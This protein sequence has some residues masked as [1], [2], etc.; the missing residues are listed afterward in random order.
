MKIIHLDMDAFYAS[1]EQRDDP[2]LRGRPVVVGGS[3]R[4]RGVVATASYE[5]RVYGVRSAMSCAEA[6]RR[7]PEAIF[8]PPDMAR[9]QEASRRVFGIFR[10]VTPIVEPLSIDEAYLDVT[11]NGLNEPLAGKVARYLK[12]RIREETGLT[13]SAGVAPSKFV[14]K[15][16]SELRKPDGLVIIPPEKVAEFVA[17]LPVEKMWG[18]GPAMAA[19]LRGLG[20][21]TAAH[22]RDGD[23]ALLTRHLGKQGAFLYQLARGEDSRVVETFR[24]PRSRGAE[25]TFP[26][27]IIDLR[28]LDYT[29]EG[30]AAEVT[31]SL[32]QMGRRARTVILKVRYSDFTT[33]TRSHTLSEPSWDGGVFHRQGRG[34]LQNTEAGI[35][36]VRLLGLSGQN[37]VRQEDPFQLSFWPP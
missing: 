15:V 10:E 17:A 25:T 37:L 8:V 34:L 36:P 6:A 13:A 28:I 27:D 5:A 29:L 14:A 16:A 3:P 4:S 33:L 22:I 2:S 1:V 30:L 21:T 18:V 7:C 20:M 23:L 32:Y 24:E 19:R 12:N 35:R 26:R 31:E 9:Y 11:T